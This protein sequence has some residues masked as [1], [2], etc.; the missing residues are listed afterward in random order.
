VEFNLSLTGLSHV[1]VGQRAD[2]L[3]LSRWFMFCYGPWFALGAIAWTRLAWRYT[4]RP[5]RVDQPADQGGQADGMRA[6]AR[7]GGMAQSR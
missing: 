5:R 4:T 7:S 1:P 3:H 2:F 6:I